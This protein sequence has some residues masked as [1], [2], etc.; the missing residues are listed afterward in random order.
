MAASGDNTVIGGSGDD[1]LNG[2]AGTD[3]LLGGAGAD[4]LNGGAGNDLLDGGSGSDTVRGDSGNDTLVYVAAQNAAVVDIYDGGSGF[5]RLRLI[6][7][8]AEWLSVAV[9]LDVQNY[10][11]FVADHA[12]P[13]GEAGFDHGDRFVDSLLRD[14]CVRLEHPRAG[15]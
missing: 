4:Q 13:N 8:S 12:L 7:T 9:Q 14:E 3:T 1:K 11:A 5:D 10:L 6:L 2:G 15:E